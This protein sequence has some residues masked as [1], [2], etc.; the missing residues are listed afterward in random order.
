VDPAFTGGDFEEV[1]VKYVLFYE[2]AGGD[3]TAAQAIFP[4]HREH[5]GAYARAGTL[6]MIG[7]FSD[8]TQGAMS[9][10]TTRE[11]AEEFVRAD[12]FVQGG[13]VGSWRIEEWNEALV[14]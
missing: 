3:R 7:P 1:D 2:S 10:F 8:R 6:L 9:V 14:P 13:V 4:A 12:P 5:Y 11:A